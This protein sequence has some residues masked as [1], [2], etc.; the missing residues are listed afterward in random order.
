MTKKREPLVFDFSTPLCTENPQIQVVIMLS[1]LF[2]DFSHRDKEIK[3]ITCRKKPLFHSPHQS[4]NKRRLK[5]SEQSKYSLAIYVFIY[6]SGNP[7]SLNSFLDNFVRFLKCHTQCSKKPVVSMTTA[8]ISTLPFFFCSLNIPVSAIPQIS[9]VLP[10]FARDTT[11][12]AAARFKHLP[13]G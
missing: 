3:L 12:S 1:F 6:S 13:R 8:C 4:G 11:A 7:A 5:T 10:V 9:S 2:S